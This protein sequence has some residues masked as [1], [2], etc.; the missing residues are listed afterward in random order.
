MTAPR[1]SRI[2][3]ALVPLALVA[4]SVA[5]GS[6]APDSSSDGTSSTVAG[7]S[8][9]VA[10]TDAPYCAAALAVNTDP[11]PDVDF[12]A[13]SSEEIAA[14]VQAYA[15]DTLRPLYEDVE[16]TAP[17][18]LSQAVETFGAAVDDLVATGDPGALDTPEMQAAS[19]AAHAYDL[20]HCAYLQAAV[21]A[22]DYEF[23]DVEPEY[24]KGP[25]SFDVTNDGT[26]VHEMVLLQVRPQVREMAEELVTLS[27]EEAL[28]KVDVV[29][30]VGP[31]APGDTGHLVA[32]LEP[33]R[34]I[35]ACFLPQ[36]STSL[37]DLET[38]DGPPHASL[39]MFRAVS[40]D[41]AP[42]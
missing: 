12:A 32:D 18:E 29:G 7:T 28:T 34:Y 8:G 5:C 13:A 30:S 41:S 27:E 24:S 15:V 23:D 36:G 39:G 9:E 11:G 33:A 42:R 40:V 22:T 38:A 10:A 3:G 35:V 1:P 31:I 37:Q 17:D 20:A 26:E 4:L 19:E 14:A 6:D 25:V 2:A 16:A 21:T